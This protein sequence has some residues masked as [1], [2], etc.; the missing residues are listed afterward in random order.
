MDCAEDPIEEDGQVILNEN[1]DMALDLGNTEVAELK[2][3]LGKAIQ[4]AVGDSD[5]LKSFDELHRRLMVGKR[6][7]QC[8]IRQ[9][10]Q[11]MSLLQAQV[12]RNKSELASNIKQLEHEHFSHY[13]SMPIGDTEHTCLVA[14]LK[15]VKKLLHK[16]EIML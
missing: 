6:L 9:H 13:N 11:L 15:Y 8:E 4:H 12:L 1:E 10:Q 3:K 2:T 5:E 7:A 14:K 16:W